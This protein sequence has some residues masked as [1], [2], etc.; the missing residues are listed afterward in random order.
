MSKLKVFCVT[1]EPI[2]EKMAGPAIRCLELAKQLALADFKVTVFTPNLTDSSIDTSVNIISD[3][4][5][6]NKFYEEAFKHDI[7]FI[8][9]NVLKEY[10]KLANCEKY[11]VVDLYD[12]Y[13][14]SV[15]AQYQN[16][17]YLLNTSYNLMH[18]IL[19]THML[20]CDFSVCANNRQRDYYLGRYCA[21]GR[22]VPQI[23]NQDNS[24][25]KLIDIIPFGLPDIEASHDTNVLRGVVP[26]FFAND[27]I[28]VW[29]GGIWDWFD[30]LT[31]IKAVG[32]L[33]HDYPDLKLFFMG[34]NSPNPQV[35]IMSMSDKALDLAKSLDV[36]QKNVFFS[37]TWIPY[38]KRGCYLLEADVA[39]SSHFDL[40]E[41]RFSFRTRI[42]DYLWA[43]LPILTSA[44]DD[45]ADLI[46]S[47]RAG[48]AL[49]V[50]SVEDWID[51]L[52]RLIIDK[53]LKDQYAKN[54]A[55]LKTQFYWS[56]VSSPLIDYCNNPYKLPKAKPVIKPGLVDR[57]KSVY[58]RGGLKGVI[59]KTKVIGQK[60]NPLG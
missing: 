21:L 36:Y 49:K 22:L 17:D 28:L 18:S 5:S 38:A 46:D 34:K 47:H 13:L 2:G 37:D 26:G 15:L 9:A 54:S 57:L 45:L 8:Q 43:N 12:P 11:L 25:K 40:I 27:T 10:P 33:S 14:F 56:A 52:K 16:N 32:A 39:V 41:T 4:P 7:F 44:G 51:A 1:L 6:H 30:P 55:S 31:I 19:D 59:N 3:L 60:I 20:A 58:I 23:Y 53:D 29:G 42:L 35:E 48:R 50:E 24:F